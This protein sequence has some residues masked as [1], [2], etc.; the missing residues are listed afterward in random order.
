MEDRNIYQIQIDNLTKQ[1][2]KLEKA[3]VE[4]FTLLHS[5]LDTLGGTFTTKKEL[6]DALVPRDERLESLESNQRW[7]VRSVIGMVVIALVGLII[8]K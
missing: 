1:V 2:D 8:K 7:L 4:G 6:T 5:K 3:T